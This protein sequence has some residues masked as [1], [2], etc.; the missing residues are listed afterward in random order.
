MILSFL[1]ALETTLKK[2]GFSEYLYWYLYK[3]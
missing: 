1:N 3:Y 2:L